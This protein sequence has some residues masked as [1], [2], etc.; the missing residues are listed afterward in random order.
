MSGLK[1]VRSIVKVGIKVYE[2]SGE[3]DVLTLEYLPSH[4]IYKVTV[5]EYISRPH[6]IFHVIQNVELVDKV[7][8]SGFIEKCDK[9]DLNIYTINSKNMLEKVLEET[10][11]INTK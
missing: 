8:L 4:L 1:D 3:S 6:L 10:K 7:K 11:N 9:N 2:V 5:L